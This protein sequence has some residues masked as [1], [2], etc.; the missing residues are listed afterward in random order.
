MRKCISLVIIGEELWCLGLDLYVMFNS[1]RGDDKA[2]SSGVFSA[3]T[4]TWAIFCALAGYTLTALLQGAVRGDVLWTLTPMALTQQQHSVILGWTH[5][6]T[7]RWDLSLPTIGVSLVLIMS[8]CIV[9][10]HGNGLLCTLMV[11]YPTKN[12][13]VLRLSGDWN[14][15]FL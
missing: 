3:P 7:V 10:L 8:V 9:I 12:V 1:C 4:N 15:F 2:C 11:I 6:I 13:K 5:Y 14:L